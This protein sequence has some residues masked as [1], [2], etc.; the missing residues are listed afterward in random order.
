MTV[1]IEC[2]HCESPQITLADYNYVLQGEEGKEMVLQETW[3]CLQCNKK[4]RLRD[5]EV[6]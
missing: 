3:K 4:T 5:G 2:P 6:L 1:L